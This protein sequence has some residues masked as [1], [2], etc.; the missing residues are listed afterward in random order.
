MS[1]VAGTAALARLALRR[2]RVMLPA[3]ILVIA[4]LTATTASSFA[5]LYPTVEARQEFATGIG[6]NPSLFALY[7]RAFDLTSVGGLTAWRIGGFA[8]VLA[9]LMSLFTVV[10]HTRAEEEAGRLELVGSG[11]VGRLAPLTAAL[12]VAFGAG[13]ILAALVA[14]GLIGV[15]LPAAGSFALGLAI[16][17]GG[18]MFA[19][20]ASTAAQLTESARAANGIAAAVLGLSYLLRAIGD[21]AGEHSWLANLSWLSPIGWTQQVRPFVGERWWV[22]GLAA[23]FAAVLTAA[24]YRLVARRDL[25]AGLLP[26]RPGPAEAARTL[27]SPLA[28]AW[29][30]HRAALAGWVAGFAVLGAALGSIAAGVG[31]LV[32]DSPQLRDLLS[33]M[34]GGRGIVDTYLNATMGIVGVIA[35]VYTVQAG[36]RLRVEETSQ[37]AE[38]VLA[39]AVS[40]VRWALSHL[41]FAVLGTAALLG[42]AGLGAGFAHGL[43]THDLGGQLPRLL[44]AALVELPAAWVLVGITAVL[45]GLVPRLSAGGWAAV[46]LFLLLGQFGPLLRLNQVIMDI[47]PF[48]HVPKVLGGELT[49]APLVWL[50]MLAGTLTAAGLVGFRH[51]DVGAG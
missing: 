3:W 39:T 19:A 36:L 2:D 5:Q 24:A 22:F 6:R 28:L 32:T 15:G 11:V 26:S 45:F 10:R 14:A 12:L 30:L 20:V 41:T 16:A 50:A 37:R 46:L 34:G 17:T 23:V 35:A 31:D 42:V 7:G 25:G 48:T 51:R 1:A 40:R 9:A 8:A 29:R 43:R 21:T 33:R 47:S 13:L 44:G 27:R 38:P 18:W 4:G 49:F